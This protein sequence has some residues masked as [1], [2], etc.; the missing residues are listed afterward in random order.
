MEV[1]AIVSPDLLSS[2]NISNQIKRLC[3][4]GLSGI[5]LRAKYLSK[6]EY[7]KLAHLALNICS[8]YDTKL[9]VNHFFEVALSINSSFWAS[10]EFI[11][12]VLEYD[13]SFNLNKPGLK[14]DDLLKFDRDIFMPIHNLKEAEQRA[15]HASYLIASPIFGASSKPSVKPAGLELILNLNIAYPDKKIIALGG[16]DAKNITKLQKVKV[17][18]VAIMGLAMQQDLDEMK[19]IVSLSYA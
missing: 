12:S 3:D 18:G 10:G 1:Y 13:N 15:R 4:I 14:L 8:K 19:K 6:N 7:E 9:V 17:A 2:K 5:V 11:S 16:I